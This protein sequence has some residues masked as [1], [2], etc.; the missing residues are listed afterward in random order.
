MDDAAFAGTDGLDVTVADGVLR[1]TLDRPA[2]L[3]A[4]TAGMSDALAA[5]LER[6]RGRDDVRVVVVAGRG[7]AFCSG[8]DLSGAD[9]HENF[10]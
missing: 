1:L 9:A 5:A 7:G 3:T 4:M 10:D 8:A 6:A 2:T